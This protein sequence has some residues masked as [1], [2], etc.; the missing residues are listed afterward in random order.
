LC[1]AAIAAYGV[2]YEVLSVSVP[3]VAS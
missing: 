3:T 1:L 2:P